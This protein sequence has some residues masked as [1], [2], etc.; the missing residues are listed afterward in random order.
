MKT[1][2]NFR[3]K[4]CNDIFSATSDD[5]TTCKCGE[6]RVRP[7]RYSTSYSGK[8]EFERL[9][10]GQD[11]TY[12]SEDDFYIIS[13]ELYDEVKYLAKELDFHIYESIEKS[14]DG[15]E[16]LNSVNISNMVITDSKR[17][18][19][20]E[21]NEQFEKSPYWS[22]WGGSPEER[23]KAFKEILIK[24]KNNEIS[25]KNTDV[26]KSI[27]TLAWDAKQVKEYDYEFYIQ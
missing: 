22:R 6:T 12:Y 19:S 15:K 14:A 1:L 18:N 24:I 10:D 9:K 7:E 17:F 26:L 27:D 13:T 8:M 5:F 3:C 25:L 4:L 11:L 20:L 2:A 23:M 16:F 21:F